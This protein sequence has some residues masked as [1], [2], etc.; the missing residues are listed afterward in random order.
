MVSSFV[1]QGEDNASDEE[2]E[3]IMTYKA[4]KWR[5]IVEDQMEILFGSETGIC[6]SDVDSM[7]RPERLYVLE[8]VRQ[9]AKLIKEIIDNKNRS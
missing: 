4:N 3:L 6:F 1:L 7:T 8:L 2:L 5:S 9:R